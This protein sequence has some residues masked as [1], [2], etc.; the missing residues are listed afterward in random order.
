MKILD[1]KIE[2]KQ[3]FL[4]IQL[5]P[6][7]VEESLDESYKRLVKE[8]D[9]PGF[10]KGKAPRSVL[11]QNIGKEAL[12]DDALNSLLPKVCDDAIKEQKIDFISRPVIKV[13]QKEPVVFEATVPLPPTVKLTDYYKIKM[14]PEPVRLNKDIV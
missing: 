3:A 11:E 4:T 1:K 10:R 14:K 6:T 13:T 7:E 8:K 12:L 2:N 5:E 9:I